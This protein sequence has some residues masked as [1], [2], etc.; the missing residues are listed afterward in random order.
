MIDL[1]KIIEA[2]KMAI[3]DTDE[4][5]SNSIPFFELADPRAVLE[6]AAM[7]QAGLGGQELARLI[8]LIRNLASCLKA[9]SGEGDAAVK[10]QSQALIDEAHCILAIYEDL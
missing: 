9:A 3:E 5:F 1:N 10:S 2:C 8:A 4:D 6:L 7:A